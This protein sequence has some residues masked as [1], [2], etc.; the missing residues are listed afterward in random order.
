A[1]EVRGQV[2][3][4]T[5]VTSTNIGM[6]SNPVISEGT[7]VPKIEITDSPYAKFHQRANRLDATPF[8]PWPPSELEVEIAKLR[9]MG[10]G[11]TAA[12]LQKKHRV[13]P[14]GPPADR[15]FDPGP[16]LLSRNVRVRCVFDPKQAVED[17]IHG[18]S[19]TD[20]SEIDEDA[21]FIPPLSH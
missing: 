15:L 10:L 12:A 9:E 20:L 5:R 17:H 4:G 13:R 19:C 21:R 18:A 11:E 6:I 7:V 3:S 14:N 8:N 2:V 1:K 16:I